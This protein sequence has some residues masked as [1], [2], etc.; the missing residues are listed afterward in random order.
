MKLVISDHISYPEYDAFERRISKYFDGAYFNSLCS[1]ELSTTR[2]LNF[3]DE[4]CPERMGR[5]YCSLPEKRKKNCDTSCL[6]VKDLNDVTSFDLMMCCPS[7]DL[8]KE[9]NEVS[10]PYHRCRVEVLEEIHV[11]AAPMKA[12]AQFVCV[13]STLMLIVSCLLICFNPRDEIEMELLKTGVM[14][15]EDVEAIRRCRDVTKRSSTIDVEKLDTMKEQQKK[16]KFGSRKRT[17]RVSP[18]N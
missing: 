11:W 14:T 12:M 6:A 10:C 1:D 4:R 2:L 15:T 9:G 8:C 5:E 3:V 7:E 18:T 16:S 13:L 17:S